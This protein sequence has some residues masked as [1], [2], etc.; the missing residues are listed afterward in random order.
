MRI[1]PTAIDDP[2]FV[3]L[4]GT[5]LQTYISSNTSKD[6]F[7]IH[8]DNWFGER[9]LGFCG[10]FRGIAGIR[11]RRGK[12]AGDRKN[13]ATP[14]FRPSRIMSE[15]RLEV[16]STGA[17]REFPFRVFHR[18]K[19][20]GVIDYLFING[21]Y[22]WYSGNTCNNTNGCIMVYELNRCGQDA[23]YIQFHKTEEEKWT[24]TRCVNTQPS[25]CIQIVEEH[26]K[27]VS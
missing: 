10:K 15:T 24:F 6:L 1:H 27:N 18:E 19:N 5:F 7:L 25:K 14:P 26:H 8:V 22:C 20:G 11:Q 16:P 17:I 4:V 2:E 13:L 12:L 3:A 21:I 23:W 9:W